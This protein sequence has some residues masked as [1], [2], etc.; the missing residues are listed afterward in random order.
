MKKV[1]VKE[2]S[3]DY[4]LMRVG[5]LEES[6]NGFLPTLFQLDPV[7]GLYIFRKE[8]GIVD[9]YYPLGMVESSLGQAASFLSNEDEILR[10]IQIFNDLFKKMLPY[11]KGEA[12][13]S[14]IN[15]LHTLYNDYI[16]YWSLVTV[17][18]YAPEMPNSSK[19]IKSLCEEGR[20]KSQE[21]ADEIEDVFRESLRLLVPALA[22]YVRFILPDEVWNKDIFKDEYKKLVQARAGGYLFFDGKVHAGGDS[23]V[24]LDHLSIEARN[25]ATETIDLRGQVAQAGKV[26]GIVKVVMHHS[27]I[28]KVEMG[29]ILVAPMTMPR[30]M[31]AME[32]AAAFVTD[33]GGLLCHAAIV[34]REMGK[35]C[36]VGTKIATDVLKDGDFVEVDA[37]EG[38]VRVINT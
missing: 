26:S 20:L 11:L 27:Q 31:P 2:L 17:I 25:T 10:Q 3:R 9:V 37:S 23:R 1:Y 4:S 30:Y 38:I 22:D 16:A 36:I 29:D 5:A 28:E 21:Y 32:K 6:V 34:S 18:Y 8:H 12:I 14:T 35:P 7:I 13:P 19:L 15:D 24:L 33:E